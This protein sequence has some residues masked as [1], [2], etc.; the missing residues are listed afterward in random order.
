ME[1]P[2]RLELY[3]RTLDGWELLLDY[4]E[5]EVTLA[6]AVFNDTKLSHELAGRKVRLVQVLSETE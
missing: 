6:Q 4:N 1:K 3:N 2:I 5:N